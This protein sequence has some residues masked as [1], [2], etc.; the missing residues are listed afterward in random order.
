M[1]ERLAQIAQ[2]YGTPC[3]VY[4]LD[5]TKQRINLL[6][7]LFNHRFQISYAIKSNPNPTLLQRLRGQVE[8]LDI[9]SSGELQ[10]AIAAGW[11]PALL[12][13]TGPGKRDEELQ[14]A[15]EHRIG[16]V[17][18]ESLHEAERLNTIARQANTTQA[19]LIRLSPLKIPRGFGVRMAGKPTQFGIDEEDIDTTVNQ[20]RQLSNLDLR[21]LH[22]YSGTQ[23]LQSDSIVEN[24]EIFIDLFRRTCDTHQLT[25][26]KLIFGS[27]LG[28]PYHDDDQPLDLAAIA[29]RINP[30][31]D[32]LRQ[33]ARFAQTQFILEI[34]RYLIG[35]AGLYL[36]SIVN[37]KRSR[38]IDICVCD[39][40]MNHH[41]GACGHLGSVIHHNYRIFK[42]T[43]ATDSQLPLQPYTLVG[44]L[45]TSIDTLGHSVNLPPLQVGDVLAIRSSGA[46]GLTASPIHFISHRPPKEILVET[47]D[48]Q[49]KTEDIS[50]LPLPPST[51]VEINS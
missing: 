4:H 29:T 1:N 31:I 13:F 49:L 23:C 34:G 12:S 44:P 14:A 10:R 18:I 24:Y 20:I 21:G 35:E 3:F 22:I 40:G 16:E 45:C 36:T 43:T 26:T 41:L 5:E 2:Q 30:A 50:Y 25:P 46:Y 39:G 48:G 11:S 28:I 9:S 37:H 7:H 38:G 32:Q 8:M 42:V 19:I 6:R 15:V 47:I 17:V 27:G 33:A 51:P